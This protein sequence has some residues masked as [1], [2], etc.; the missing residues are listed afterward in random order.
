M[1]ADAIVV[2]GTDTGVGKTVLSAMLT[3][4]LDASYWKPVQ[5]GGSEGTDS[6][7]VRALTGLPAGRFLPERYALAAPLSPHRA[8]ELAGVCL[9]PE[10]LATLPDPGGPLVVEL[11]GG[12]LVPL[13]RSFL[14]IELLRLWRA[15]VVL[16]ARTS[17]GTINHALLSCEA[18]RA[19]GI[20][21][22]GVAFVGEA[23][24]DS[25]RTVAELSGARRL[26]RLPW[27]EDPG[28][29]SL[30]RAFAENFSLRD[31]FPGMEAAR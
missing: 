7:R 18:L 26:G 11:A 12:L 13:T 2:A 27:L 30:R 14:Q 24:E 23:N 17:L 20:G 3:L 5:S 4:A 31:F 6:A 10:A 21:L 25:E 16:C 9:S 28:P 19:R 15:P 1:P 8:A 29:A 22:L